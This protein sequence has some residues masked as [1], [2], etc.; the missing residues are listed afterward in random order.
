MREINRFPENHLISKKR[1][2]SFEKK[3]CFPRIEREDEEAVQ[4]GYVMGTDVEED[5]KAL[6][7]RGVSTVGSQQT[8]HWFHGD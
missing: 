8:V 4:P 3:R 1:T 2:D 7:V 6:V 5:E